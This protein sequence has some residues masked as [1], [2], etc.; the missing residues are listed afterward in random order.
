MTKRKRINNNLQN[1]R[2]KTKYQ[3][4]Q[5]PLKTGGTLRCCEG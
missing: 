5:T 2:E 1:I 3:A 4:T